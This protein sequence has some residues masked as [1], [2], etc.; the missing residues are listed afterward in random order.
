MLEYCVIFSSIVC[1][2]WNG[3]IFGYSP[4]MGRFSFV[5]KYFF[6]NVSIR[7]MFSLEL[8]AKLL[9]VSESRLTKLDY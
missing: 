3:F 9:C 1:C 2:I 6:S 8:K 7:K 5:A 4:V